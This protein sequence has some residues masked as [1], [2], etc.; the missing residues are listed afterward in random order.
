[1]CVG[2]A[3][4]R[5]GKHAHGREAWEPAREPR[6]RLESPE[7]RTGAEPEVPRVVGH[8]RRVLSEELAEGDMAKEP[9]WTSPTT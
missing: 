3:D 6:Q 9:P 2:E 1:M 5:E 7:V 4:S 8:H